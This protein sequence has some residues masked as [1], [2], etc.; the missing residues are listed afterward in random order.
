MFAWAVFD[1]MQNYATLIAGVQSNRVSYDRGLFFSRNYIHRRSL[2]AYRL[3]NFTVIEYML[4]SREYNKFVS[5]TF[6]GW[7]L[8]TQYYY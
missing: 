4:I 3:L 1:F 2:L 5:N 8:N 7:A 6:A